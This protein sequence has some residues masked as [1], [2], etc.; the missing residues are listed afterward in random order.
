MSEILSKENARCRRV[1]V[2][3]PVE[4][5][6]DDPNGNNKTADFEI[7]GYTGQVVRR[8]Y[9]RLAVS[10]EGIR[11]KAKLPIFKK[12]DQD[13]VVGYS[14]KTWKDNGKF[15]LSGVFSK[16][17]EA[18][19]EVKGLADEGFPWQASIG[20]EPLEIVSIKDGEKLE[21]N[22]KTLKGPAEVWT[23]S[24][25]FETSFVSFGADTQ[26]SVAVF[27]AFD[28]DEAPW[29]DDLPAGAKNNLKG[30]DDKMITL[31]QLKKDA[32]DLLKQIQDA[33]KKEGLTEGLTQGAENE[34]GRI[35]GVSACL[36]PG[37]EAL[38]EKLMYDGTTT[39]GDAAQAVLAAEKKIRMNAGQDLQADGVTPVVH[40]QGTDTQV[41]AKKG[42][43]LTK[44]KFDA[45]A[46]L[47]EEFD[48]DFDAYKAYTQAMGNGQVKAKIE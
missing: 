19:T 27:S 48:G 39:S 7:T 2:S 29:A 16:I 42:A 47:S 17:T 14:K 34:R 23:K 24:Q 30:S 35:Q 13:L 44:E 10:V 21:V 11:A 3:A 40:A 15:M 43:L 6:R 22:G 9:G 36:M 18:A 38:I 45:D 8:W 31:E 41:P 25:V 5:L 33:A 32:P 12:H 4:L 46:K 37:H 20:V 1:K 26:T 28:E